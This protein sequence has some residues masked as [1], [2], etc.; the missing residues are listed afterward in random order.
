MSLKMNLLQILKDLVDGFE[1]Q[2]IVRID[3]FDAG[4]CVITWKFPRHC[5]TEVSRGISAEDLQDTKKLYALKEEIRID[6]Q[7][8]GDF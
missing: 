2:P 3:Y 4:G 5:G 7:Q 8:R 6:L 1:S